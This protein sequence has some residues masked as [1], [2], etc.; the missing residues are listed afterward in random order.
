MTITYIK[1]NDSRKPEYQLVTTIGERDGRRFALKQAASPA[2]EDFL[3]SLFVKYQTLAVP[4]F[5]LKPL[6]PQVVEGGVRFAFLE[7]ESLDYQAGEAVRAGDRESLL[8]VFRSY[9]GLVDRIPAAEEAAADGGFGSFFGAA[10]T[11]A[12]MERL[13]SGCLDLI[14]ENI[15]RDNGEYVLIDYEW[16]FDFPLPK[17]LILLRTVMNTYYKYHAGGINQ[18]LPVDHLYVELGIDPAAIETLMRMEWAFQNAVNDRVQPFADFEAL[19]DRV[20]REPYDG[21]LSITGLR[22]R[23][24]L[25]EAELSHTRQ[26]LSDRDDE[27]ASMRASKFWK[28]RMLSARLARRRR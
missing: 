9:R 11:A 10:E 6:E 8:A 27:I 19:Y 3:A 18:L 15:Y 16:T 20:L 25:A 12:G 21:G 24:T 5:P 17:A 13:A 7:G 28:L 23:F 4:G 14:L 22:E 26:M 1:Y 2:A